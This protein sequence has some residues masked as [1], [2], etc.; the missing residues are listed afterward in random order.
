M[1]S[2]GVSASNGSQA[3]PLLVMPAC[4]ISKSAPRGRNKPTT[5]PARRAALRQRAANRVAG[6]VQFA[7]GDDAF[8]PNQRRMLRPAAR[9]G[10]EDVRETFL[11]QQIRPVRAAQHRRFRCRGDRGIGVGI[12]GEVYQATRT[13]RRV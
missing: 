8:A 11:A 13:P 1:R 10:G 5:L 7:V 4:A 6:R 9:R 3:A 2:S 12:F